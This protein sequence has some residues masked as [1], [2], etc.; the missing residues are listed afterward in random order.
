[1]SAHV[2]GTFQTVSQM[3]QKQGG[4]SSEKDGDHEKVYEVYRYYSHTSNHAN[5]K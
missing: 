3:K 1:M 5:R 4:Q 2:Y